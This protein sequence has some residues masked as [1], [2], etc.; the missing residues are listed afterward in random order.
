MHSLAW[1]QLEDLKGEFSAVSRTGFLMANEISTYSL[2]AAAHQARTLLTPGKGA[3]IT[4]SYIGSQ[5]AVPNYNI[6]GVAKAGL[7]SAMRY[8]AAEF[9]PQGIRV[10]AIS[11]GPIETLS[12]SG[13]QGFDRMLKTAA[14]QSPLRRNVSS[15]E[16]GDAGAFLCSD[17]AQ[18]ITGQVLYVD[19]G[20]HI[21]ASV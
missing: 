4:L 6:M 16:V 17:L 9:G 2:V 11:A 19:A 8:L 7:E 3:I 10:N 14:E 1:A 21:S 15:K 18:G 20:Y 5:R 13:I 12:A